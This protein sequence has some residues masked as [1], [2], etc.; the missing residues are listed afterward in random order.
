VINLNCDNCLNEE[1]CKPKIFEGINTYGKVGD[2]NSLPK[3]TS[4]FLILTQS[5]NLKCKYCFVKQKPRNMTYQIAQDVVEFLVKNANERGERPSINY[6]GGE[7]LL[8]WDEIIVPLTLYIREKYGENFELSMTTNGVL[9]DK[10]KLEFMKTHKIGFMVS[11]DGDKC[12]Q[13]LNRPLQNG[14][15]SF[16]ILAPRIPMF[17]EYNPI[18]TFRATVDHDNVGEYFNTHKFAIDNGYTNVFTIVNVFTAWSQE[19]KAE[20]KKQIRMTVD[21]YL[22][23]LGK[24]KEVSFSPFGTMFQKMKQINQ[25]ITNNQFRTTG[26]GMLGFGRCGL[27]ASKFAS[28]GTDGTLYS[29]QEMCDNDERGGFFQIGNIYEGENN[30]KRM[31]VINEF[32]PKIVHSTEYMECKECPFNMICDGACTINNYFATGDLNV[33]P[34]ILCY[35]YQCLYYEAV[36]I[37][38]LALKYERMVN[39]FKKNRVLT[40]PIVKKDTST[41]NK[42]ACN[43]NKDKKEVI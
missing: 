15:S 2:I 1:K 23:L 25:A 9:L 30:E 5:C 8:K 29:C 22:E 42:D 43:C 19:E 12:T 35:Y 21:Y 34:S 4:A 13:D 3:I 31:A 14:D 33:M 40:Q 10:E 32:N 11:F 24:G 7:P 16:D 6:F 28:V 27:G 36:R 20:L 26:E 37:T 17:L 39:I 18:M 38:Q 41:C